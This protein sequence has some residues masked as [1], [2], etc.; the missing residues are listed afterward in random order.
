MFIS[1]H[2]NETV[3]A[4]EK[5]REMF[6]NLDWKHIYRSTF[7]STIDSKLRS[8]QYKYLMR[9]VPTNE[10]LHRCKLVSSSLCELCDMN[11]EDQKHLFWACTRIQEFWSDMKR[12]FDNRN[13]N[14]TVDYRLVSFGTQIE[15]NKQQIINSIVIMAKYYIFKCK[16]EKS[17]P[18][19]T[20][21]NNT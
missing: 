1:K 13:I 19:F 20:V 9:I 3:K 8:F 18:N 2:Q 4:Q 10:Y 5:W 7:T 6:E 17:T 11:V 15:P 16:L 21:S 12:F 14:I